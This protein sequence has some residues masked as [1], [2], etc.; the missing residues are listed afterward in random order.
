MQIVDMT[1]HIS[2]ELDLFG[3]FILEPMCENNS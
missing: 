1:K 2:W 3:G